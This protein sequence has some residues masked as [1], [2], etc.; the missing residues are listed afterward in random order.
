MK[1][2]NSYHRP[3]IV[4]W[5]FPVISCSYIWM[6][7]CDSHNIQLVCFVLQVKKHALLRITGFWPNLTIAGQTCTTDDTGHYLRAV[8][9]NSL[10]TLC[11]SVG[12]NVLL[13]STYSVVHFINSSKGGGWGVLLF[14]KQNKEF[15]LTQILDSNTKKIMSVISS[16]WDQKTI[17]VRVHLTL[18]N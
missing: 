17:T 7:R 2:I 11:E 12:G 14:V 10:D 1:G 3:L 4:T 9:S 18:I 8:A 15:S 13:W 6:T 16:H 5:S